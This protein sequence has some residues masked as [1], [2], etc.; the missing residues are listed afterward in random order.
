MR[1]LLV[2]VALAT[3]GVLAV[4]VLGDLTQSRPDPVMDEVATEL[5]VAVDH[6][7]FGGGVDAAADAL[8]AVCSAQTASRIGGDRGLAPIG[9]GRYRAVLHPAV[10]DHEQRKLVGCLEDLT[11]DRVVGD[12]ESFETLPVAPG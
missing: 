4:D 6:D 1:R 9:D 8:W 3:A 7:R 11:V 2:A 10:G 5:V 12:V